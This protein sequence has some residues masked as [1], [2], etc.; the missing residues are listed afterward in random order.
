MN[1]LSLFKPKSGANLKK[2]QA[3]IQELQQFK[4]ELEQYHW[5]L[6]TCLTS[7]LQLLVEFFNSTSPRSDADLTSS[8]ANTFSLSHSERELLK[9][10]AVHLRQTGRDSYGI[11]RTIYAQ[12]VCAKDVYLGGIYGFHTKNVAEIE[13]HYAENYQFYDVVNH[14]ATKYMVSHLRPMIYLIE[15]L[16]RSLSTK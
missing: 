9:G 13:S 15:L 1:V 6:T 16:V 8:I 2:Q 12:P 11:N 4:A 14:Q 5:R 3:I 10:L 7:S